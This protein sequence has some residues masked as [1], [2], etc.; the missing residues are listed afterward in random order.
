LTHA[1]NPKPHRSQHGDDT[2]NSGDI[3]ANHTIANGSPTT[4]QTTATTAMQMTATMTVQ[5][6]SNDN[7]ANDGNDDGAN[8]SNDHG[9][10]NSN[11]DD[12]A[13]D[14]ND[15]DK[16]TRI[17]PNNGGPAGESSP[18][19]MNPTNEYQR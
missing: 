13:K 12:D 14:S 8:D 11:D 10:N 19:T 3:D 18:M 15:D 16:S 6:D 17:P 2:N 9:A 7:D 5:T 4:M 1:N